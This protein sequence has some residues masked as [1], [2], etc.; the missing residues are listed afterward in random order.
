MGGRH[1]TKVLRNTGLDGTR[2]AE[3]SEE[4]IRFYNNVKCARVFF[5]MS[6]RE[7][8]TRTSV[9]IC[10]SR[11]LF[12]FANRVQS[13]Y[14]LDRS[15]FDFL[16]TFFEAIAKKKKIKKIPRTFACKRDSVKI[17]YSF[18]VSKL[19]VTGT[20]NSH[21]IRAT[22]R[23]LYWRRRDRIFQKISFEIS[24]CLYTLYIA[25]AYFGV[26]DTQ[27]KSQF[28]VNSMLDDLKKKN[29]QTF[30]T[31]CAFRKYLENRYVAISF[32]YRL[33]DSSTKRVLTPT[34]PRSRSFCHF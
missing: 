32:Y 25:F 21:Q 1:S 13:P 29:R 31:S 8:S 24:S 14:I 6:A 19:I 30:V 17:D 9:P 16:D 11:N 22:S 12:S 23:T 33:T 5:S 28:L 15:F 20:R 2:D 3:R 18:V 7:N 26:F 27:K 34:K 4:C 10:Y